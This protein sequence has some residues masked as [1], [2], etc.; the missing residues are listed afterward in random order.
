MQRWSRSS[1][2]L[3]TFVPC[4]STMPAKNCKKSIIALATALRCQ[5]AL[6]HFWP[7]VGTLRMI[8]RLS[9]I[10]IN[11]E[12]ILGHC[13]YWW[14]N[15]VTSTCSLNCWRPY[16][17]GR[18]L[19]AIPLCTAGLLHFQETISPSCFFLLTRNTM[20]LPSAIVKQHPLAIVRLF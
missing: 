2:I 12:L 4:M 16:V 7:F 13:L 8:L 6:R 5:S 11:S 1:V 14:I 17:V 19:S 20:Y 9:L 3:R 10:S 15:S 18:S